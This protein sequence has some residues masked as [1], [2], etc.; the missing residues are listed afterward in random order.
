MSTVELSY[1][2]CAIIIGRLLSSEASVESSLER[3]RMLTVIS[4]YSANTMDY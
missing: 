1:Y 2:A 4:Y 3:P